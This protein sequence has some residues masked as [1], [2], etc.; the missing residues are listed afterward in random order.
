MRRL[1]HRLLIAASIASCLPAGM[2]NA[3]EIEPG[4]HSVRAMVAQP[5]SI[6]VEGQGE[7]E[8]VPDIAEIAAGVTARADT[9]RE[10]LDASNATMARLMA[11]LRA[12]GVT[13]R[14]TRTSSFAVMPIYERADRNAP[15][16]IAAY[17]A[18][19]QVTVRIH[20]LSRT[21]AVLDSMVTAGSNR[22]QGI[23][24]R[25]ADPAALLDLAR[26]KAFEDARR[27]AGIY[28]EAAGARLGKV[29]TIS[30]QTAR[31][32]QPRMFAVEAMAASRDVPVSPGT[33]ELAVTVSVRFTLE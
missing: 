17:D 20:D 18:T 27:R 13:E 9:A 19:N 30:E 7:I 28:A 32:P 26:G 23:R 6:T 14:D 16:R 12:A 4:E 1:F 24:F 10:A 3:A 2:A 31:L 29:L 8:A 11:A 22:V 15:R 5:R 33:Q 25:I 21:G